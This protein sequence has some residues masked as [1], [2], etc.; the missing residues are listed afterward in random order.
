MSDA[1]EDSTPED[2]FDA[3][4][5]ED[6]ARWELELLWDELCRARRD[7]IN[8]VWS[9]HCDTLAARIRM[10][11]RLVGPTPWEKI[12]FPLLEDGTYQ[13]IHAEMGVPAEVD[14]ERVAATRRSIDQRHERLRPSHR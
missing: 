4:T 2:E 1:S 5:L 7:A 3:R 13:R 11:T 6:A 12:Q 9:M 14:M 10:F 8:G